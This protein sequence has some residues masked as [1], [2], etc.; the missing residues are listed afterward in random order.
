[1][2]FMVTAILIVALIVAYNISSTSKA[3]ELALG[4]FLPFII[5]GSIVLI[6]FVATGNDPS[7]GEKGLVQKSVAQVVSVTHSVGDQKYMVEI[8]KG[9]YKTVE[10]YDL[11]YQGPVMKNSPDKIMEEV[12]VKMPL[13]N[14]AFPWEYHRAHEDI[15][16]FPANEIKVVP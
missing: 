6:G 9:S 5:A 4:W 8:D 3:E 13:M 1:M 10:E 15:I 7:D 11:S 12:Y 16:H 2:I 14:W